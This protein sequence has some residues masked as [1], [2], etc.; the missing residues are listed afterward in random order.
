[1][2]P[3]NEFYICTVA[4][5]AFSTKMEDSNK[6]IGKEGRDRGERQGRRDGGKETERNRHME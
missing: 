5:I 1:L 6:G 2:L 4:I 3:I